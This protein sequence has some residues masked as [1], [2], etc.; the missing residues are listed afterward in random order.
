M[1]QVDPKV[2]FWLSVAI[3][4]CGVGSNAAI[5]AGALPPDVITLVAQWNRIFSSVGQVVLPLFLGQGMTTQG[6]LAAVAALPEVKSIVTTQTVADATPS[7]KVVGP[8]VGT[9][10]K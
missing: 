10:T 3:A 6:R 1:P 9:G 8:P 2:I 7:D 4:V 5:W